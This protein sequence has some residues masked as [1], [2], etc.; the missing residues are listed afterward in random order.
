MF[1][2]C[3]KYN[4]YCRISIIYFA[5]GLGEQQ[6]YSA[7]LLL[8]TGIISIVLDCKFDREKKSILAFPIGTEKVP[9]VREDLESTSERDNKQTELNSKKLELNPQSENNF[10]NC[11]DGCN[12]VSTDTPIKSNPYD[13]PDD[14]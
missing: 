2:Y 4:L 12:V 6:N 9:Y 10:N 8:F 11:T 14:F 1:T 3:I 7:Y 5:P 13:I